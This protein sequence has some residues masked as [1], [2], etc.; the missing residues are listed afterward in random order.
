MMMRWVITAQ[1][2]QG[3]GRPEDAMQV[4]LCGWAGGLLEW[5]MGGRLE[6]GRGAC[7]RVVTASSCLLWQSVEL[8]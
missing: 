2:S 7:Q 1:H 8:R 6:G 3:R 5:G 4:R